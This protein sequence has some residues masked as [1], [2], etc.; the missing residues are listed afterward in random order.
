MKSKKIFPADTIVT[1]TKIFEKA[2]NQDLNHV[3]K[4]G[5]RVRIIRH[6][7]SGDHYFPKDNTYYV[8]SAEE[9]KFKAYNEKYYKFL[10]YNWNREF[11]ETFEYSGFLKP[12]CF[13]Q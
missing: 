7:R 5:S 1:I 10:K 4:I 12:D 8:E 11:A 6:P 9:P 2:N 3:F 13:E